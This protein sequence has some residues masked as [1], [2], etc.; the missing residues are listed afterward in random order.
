M[1]DIEL[2]LLLRGVEEVIP[3]K[4]FLEQL[5]KKRPLRIKAL[6]TAN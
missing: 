2:D 5:K 4:D 3:K 1:K 6:P